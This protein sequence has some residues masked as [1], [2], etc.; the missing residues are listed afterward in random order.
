MTRSKHI[1]RQLLDV[2]SIARNAETIP[3]VM[4]Y[5]SD[6]PK[7]YLIRLTNEE[8]L[9]VT[10]KDGYLRLKAKNIKPLIEELENIL[11]DIEHERG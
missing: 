7:A 9:I 6:L 4:V 3:G 11:E 2:E 5:A 8:A 1:T 10:A